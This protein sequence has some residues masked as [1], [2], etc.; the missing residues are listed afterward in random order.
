MCVT[1]RCVHDRKDAD[2][3]TKAQHRVFSHPWMDSMISRRPTTVSTSQ[4]AANPSPVLDCAV[5]PPANFNLVSL[6]LQIL[7]A[8][9]RSYRFSVEKNDNMAFFVNRP[10]GWLPRTEY[11]DAMCKCFLLTRLLT[12]GFSYSVGFYIFLLAFTAHFPNH[13]PSFSFCFLIIQTLRTICTT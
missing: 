3:E 5:A 11:R 2:G 6:F 1:S 10:A 8:F 7:A 4:N 12:L 13:L 9:F